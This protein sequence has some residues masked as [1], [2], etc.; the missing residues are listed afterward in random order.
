ME[1]Q[2]SALS[3]ISQVGPQLTEAMSSN[4]R[5]IRKPINNLHQPCV[6]A[7]AQYS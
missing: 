3:F 2:S 4:Q 6:T 1:R 7:Y 5:E